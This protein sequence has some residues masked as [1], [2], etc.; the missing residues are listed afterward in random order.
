MNEDI[1]IGAP[2][3]QGLWRN[4]DFLKLWAGETIS[5]F[6]SFIGGPAL[7]FAAVITLAATPFQMALLSAA[8]IIPGLL[9]PFAGVWVDRLR[10]R[11]IMIVCDL[12]LT[13]V[14]FTVPLAA[15]AHLLSM[16]QLYAVVFITAALDTVFRIAYGAYLPTLVGRDDIVEANSKLT[17]SSAV[18]EVSGFALAGW[19]VQWLTAPFAVAIDAL[20]FLASIVTLSA[21]EKPEEP[22]ARQD[23]RRQMFTE[24]GEGARFIATDARLLTIAVCTA[25]QTVFD[26][27]VGA[28]YMLF[29]VN[30]LGFKP[31]Q[32]GVIFAIGGISSF[33]GALLARRAAQT[34]G[35]V[36]S[37]AAGVGIAGVGLMLVPMARGAGIYGASMLIG[38]QLIAD[39]A[40]TIFIINYWSYVQIVTPDEILGRVNS[41][42]VFSR[43]VA[44]LAGSLIAGV[45]GTALGLRSPLYIAALGTMLAALVLLGAPEKVASTS[46]GSLG[47]SRENMV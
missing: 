8:N 36:R 43:R 27:I 45:L 38:N 30:I 47:N 39:G 32:L 37:M 41:C 21:I 16:R 40:F 31:G 12:A 46:R 42:L 24:I 20:S 7:R 18:A 1:T 13:V 23:Q 26:N 14:L 9:S 35:L 19:L 22:V 25:V 34:L 33:V 11:R 2:T 3:R 17:A 5:E 28:L 29:V 10:R 44:A 6:G 15:V 4:P